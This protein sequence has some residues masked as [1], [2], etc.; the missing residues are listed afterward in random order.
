MQGFL[1]SL[2]NKTPI[3]F[4]SGRRFAIV[5]IGIAAPAIVALIIAY[6]MSRRS[7][8]SIGALAVVVI[9]AGE[10]VVA[11][12]VAYRMSRRRCVR[13]RRILSRGAR[14]EARLHAERREDQK[15]GKNQKLEHRIYPLLP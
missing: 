4:V 12:C 10:T 5:V 14:P 6:R 2:K 8:L 15:R 9:V 3:A 13:P 1:A 7:I 11:L